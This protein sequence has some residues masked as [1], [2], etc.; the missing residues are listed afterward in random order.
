MLDNHETDIWLSCS[1]RDGG[2]QP[3]EGL[4][5]HKDGANALPGEFNGVVATPR[6]ACPSIAAPNKDQIRFST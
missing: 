2:G 4:G 1:L 6:R 5:T 3:K